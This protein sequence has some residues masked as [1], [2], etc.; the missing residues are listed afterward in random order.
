[1]KMGINENINAESFTVSHSLHIV[2]LLYLVLIPTY[3]G[4]LWDEWGD[5]W[6]YQYVTS[7]FLLIFFIYISNVIPSPGFPSITPY[8]NSPYPFSMRVF[9]QPTSQPWHSPTLGVQPWKDQG[10]LLPWCTTRSPSATYTARAMG[11][12]M[13][14]LYMVV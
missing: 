4:S 9:P 6:A 12:S 11:L 14:T 2:Q 8:P 1:M 10:L 7:N 5:L 13:C 3:W